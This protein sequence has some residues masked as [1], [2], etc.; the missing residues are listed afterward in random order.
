MSTD[1]SAGLIGRRGVLK[2]G[3]TTI[4]G[5]ISKSISINSEPVDITSD[6]SIGFRELLAADSSIKTVEISAEGILKSNQFFDVVLQPDTGSAYFFEFGTE[7]KQLVGTFHVTALEVG[8]PMGEAISVSLTLQS[9]G[10][11]INGVVTP[12]TL[13]WA[14][15]IVAWGDQILYWDAP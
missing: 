2:K 14:D 10:F 15:F 4:G 5:L 1:L 11:V 13:T 12:T 3:S 8:A 7:T 6:D 9:S